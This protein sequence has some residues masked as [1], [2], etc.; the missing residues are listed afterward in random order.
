LRIANQPAQ[1]TLGK[2]GAKTAPDRKE[3][4]FMHISRILFST[5]LAGLFI[6]SAATTG[7]ANNE[8][9]ANDAAPAKSEARV[10]DA[11]EGEHR[12]HRSPPGALS[13]L[14]APFILKVDRL[15]GGAP[16]F[17]MLTEDIPP[18]QAIS[19]HRHPH[20]DEII[21]IHGGTGLAAL[22]GRQA[23]VTTGATIYMP[24]NTVVGL[25]NTGTEP[26][27]IVAIFSKPGFE[28]YLRDISVP[29]GETPTPLSVDELSA[30]RARHV[31]SAVYEK[32]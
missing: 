9:S 11:S 21:F 17:V 4:T 20:S 3:G 30:I 16:E 29:E 18:G 32:P 12:L 23:T 15:N 28:E 10:L 1:K 27:K 19:P 8:H 26:L 2:S 31:G 25:R 7:W 14:R 6:A 24:R 5:V 13:T 22:A